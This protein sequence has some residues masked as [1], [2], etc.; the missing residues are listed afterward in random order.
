[1]F[2]DAIVAETVSQTQIL[3]NLMYFTDFG[4]FNGAE[5]L[6]LF[7]KVRYTFHLI[8]VVKTSGEL[9]LIGDGAS[10]LDQRFDIIQ[11]NSLTSVPGCFCTE[12]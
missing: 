6:L 11:R 9:G 3:D 10:F 12:G 1:M 4:L 7:W 5:Y 8:F 2:D